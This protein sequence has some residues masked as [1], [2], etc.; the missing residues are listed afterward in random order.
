MEGDIL[1]RQPKEKAML[2][3]SKNVEEV[4]EFIKTARTLKR[5]IKLVRG[6]NLEAE[7]EQVIKTVLEELKKQ[8][9]MFKV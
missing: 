8:F 3:N 4:I 1:M 9:L 5:Q 7:E 2:G 6:I